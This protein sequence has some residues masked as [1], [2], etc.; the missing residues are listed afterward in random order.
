[1]L[2]RIMLSRSQIEGDDWTFSDMSHVKTGDR[3]WW[4]WLTNYFDQG[5]VVE[6]IEKCISPDGPAS[7]K[8]ESG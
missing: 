8:P 7:G 2:Y 3:I 5:S 1:M 4:T 6:E